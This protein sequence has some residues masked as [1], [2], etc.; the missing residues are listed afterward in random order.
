M[1]MLHIHSYSE[2]IYMHVNIPALWN[3]H[4]FCCDDVEYRHALI[5]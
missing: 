3:A 2:R 5:A 4:E 1:F